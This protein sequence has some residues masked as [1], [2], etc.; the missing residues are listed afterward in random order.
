MADIRAFAAATAG[1]TPPPAGS[2][3]T[4][5]RLLNELLE[6]LSHL[7][8][9]RAQLIEQVAAQG[10]PSALA[11]VAELLNQV[12]TFVTARTS[13][14]TLLPSRVLARVADAIP[15]TQLLG[16][17]QERITVSTAMATL[18]EWQGE[19]CD[20]R[21]LLKDLCEA[22]VDVLAM[23]C[24]AITTLFRAESDREEWRTMSQLFVTDLRNTFR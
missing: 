14:P 19:A 2:R 7:E 20:R 15:Y 11:R 17:E 1:P 22:T 10:D 3:A 18:K 13:D 8:Q 12:V 24:D 5:E 16:E 21:V 23:Y 9:H 4:D 6:L